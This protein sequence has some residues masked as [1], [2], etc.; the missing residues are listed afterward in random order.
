M[1]TNIAYSFVYFSFKLKN[2]ASE[3]DLDK[4]MSFAEVTYSRY[5]TFFINFGITL[6]VTIKFFKCTLFPAVFLLLHK[7]T[8]TKSI[9]KIIREQRIVSNFR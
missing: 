1:P 2:K 9:T 8:K 7:R 5:N 3:M 6:S 4:E